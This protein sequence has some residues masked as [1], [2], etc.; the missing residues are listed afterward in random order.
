MNEDICTPILQAI[1]AF[2]YPAA[3]KLANKLVRTYQ[4]LGNIINKLINCESLYT[5]LSFMKPK[6]FMRK[7]SLLNSMYIYLSEDLNKEYH[8]LENNTTITNYFE[9]SAYLSIMAGI[10][11]LCTLRQNLINITKRL[12]FLGLGI[13]KEI[14]ILTKLLQSRKD[15]INYAFQDACMDLFVC[16]QELM[17]WK[18]QCH[19]QDYPEKSSIRHEETKEHIS[20]PFGL[21]SSYN[22]NDSKNQKQGDHWPPTIRWYCKYLA[23]LTAKMTLYFHTILLSK[24]RILVEDDPERSLWKGINPDYY[25]MMTSFRKKHGAQYI[26]LVYEVKKDKPFY[27]EG[28]VCHGIP[29]EPPQGIHSFPFIFSLPSQPPNDHLPNIISIIQGSQN[30]LND[31]KGMPFHFFDNMLTS[32]YYLARVDEHTILVIIYQDKHT[33]KESGTI[34]FMTNLV[35][36]LRGSAVIA[37]LLRMD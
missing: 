29:Y 32:T 10:N 17:D 24:E 34:T 16:K 30:K 36:L 19:T 28:F 12:G 18:S 4:P 23:N 37:E 35:S 3:S 14:Q 31:P 6:W 33:Q 5:Q 26:G 21:F 11:S 7:D 27:P 22:N 25:D 15:I 20:W 8:A 2:D 13:K 9:R 1:G